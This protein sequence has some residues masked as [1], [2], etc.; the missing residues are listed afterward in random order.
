M[1]MLPLRPSAIARRQKTCEQS[2]SPRR[3]T[4]VR[5]VHW[6]SVRSRKGTMVSMPALLTRM[7]MGPEFVPH[8]VDHGLHLGAVGDVGLHRDGARPVPRIQAATS[9]AA[10]A[11]A[12]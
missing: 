1:T 12:M 6:S 9:S 5:R 3:L 11:L 2:H 4:S 8:L 10:C 7:S